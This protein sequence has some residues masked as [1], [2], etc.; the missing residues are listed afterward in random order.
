MNRN[1]ALAEMQTMHSSRLVTKQSIIGWYIFYCH[2]LPKMKPERSMADLV[3][4]IALWMELTQKGGTPAFPYHY[5]TDIFISA[6]T[7]KNGRPD[8]YFGIS[9]LTL[10][11][12]IVILFIRP[13]IGL[14]TIG[15]AISTIIINYVT[16]GGSRNL[17]TVISPRETVDA[18]IWLRNR[19]VSNSKID[20]TEAEPGSEKRN[21][22]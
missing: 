8:P 5:K 9:M 12:G 13:G 1:D 10:F 4:T 17:D 21:D 18:V 15:I 11:V 14:F 3:R 22:N 16:R 6:G 19:Y 20:S 7:D 2:K